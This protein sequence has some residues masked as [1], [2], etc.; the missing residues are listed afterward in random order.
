MTINKHI[1]E[2]TDGQTFEFDTEEKM[3]AFGIKWAVGNLVK[4]GYGELVIDDQGEEA[5]R[6]NEKGIAHFQ[7]LTQP[8]SH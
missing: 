3:R 2:A 1:F 5:F 4:N 7:S 6:I 8:V